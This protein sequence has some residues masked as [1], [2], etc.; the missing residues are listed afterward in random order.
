MLEMFWVFLESDLIAPNTKRRRRA[1]SHTS[2]QPSLCTL[3]CG[4]G[5]WMESNLRFISAKACS[6]WRTCVV[7]V[8]TLWQTNITMENHHFQ[9]E[10]ALFLWSLSIANCKRL[11]A[12][13]C[14]CVLGMVRVGQMMFLWLEQPRPVAVR[15]AS[16]AYSEVDPLTTVFWVKNSEHITLWLELFIVVQMFYTLNH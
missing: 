4:S 13:I 15:F 6:R 3:G 9:W 16:N 7:T 10:N 5:Q 8:T 1:I 12:G 11:P 2:D 14:N